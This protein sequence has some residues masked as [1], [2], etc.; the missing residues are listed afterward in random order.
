MKLNWKVYCVLATVFAASMGTFF[1]IPDGRELL[2]AFVAAPGVIALLGVLLQLL[3][4]EADYEKRLEIQRK[5]FQFSLG[6]A[7]HMAN[8]A[9]DRHVEFCEKYMKAL[10][11]TVQTLWREGDTPAALDH[12]NNLYALRQDYATWLTDRINDDLGEF[13]SALRKLGAD[14]HFIRST[15]GR[16]GYSEQRAVRIESNFELFDRILGISKKDILE[17]SL[18]EALKAKVRTILGVEELTKLR[19]HLI[20]QASNA[21]NA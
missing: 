9:F 10:H 16:E 11:D 19:D 14:A 18:V 3:R 1:L 12:A 2:G 8:A 5:E 6:A 4:D 7:S 21:I 13:E 17:K 20:K 15:S